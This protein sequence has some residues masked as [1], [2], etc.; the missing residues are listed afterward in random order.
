M[1]TQVEQYLA[2]RVASADPDPFLACVALYSPHQPWAITPEF[3]TSSNHY[4]D[5][6]RVEVALP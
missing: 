5:F 1:I 4:A 2:D 3:N 6:V